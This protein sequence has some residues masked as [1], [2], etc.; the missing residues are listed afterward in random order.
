MFSIIVKGKDLSELKVNVRKLSEEMNGGMVGI[1]GQAIEE[2]AEAMRKAPPIDWDKLNQAVENRVIG[3]GLV[4][5]PFGAPPPF[6]PPETASLPIDEEASRPVNVHA[7]L[8]LTHAPTNIPIDPT[9][10]DSKGLPWDERIHASSKGKSADGSWRYRRGSEKA[11]I[12]AVENE[13]RARLGRPVETPTSP[14][15][16]MASIL[17]FQGPQTT[18]SQVAPPTTPVVQAA[19]PTH[20]PAIP[21]PAP[22]PVTLAHSLDTFKTN[23]ELTLA[24]LVKQGKITQQY[25]TELLTFFKVPQLWDLNDDQKAA[26]F[27]QFAQYGFIQKVV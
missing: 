18:L 13:L 19:Q 10:V 15:V 20:Q 8:P 23:F 17:P 11:Q 26:I 2:A 16:P 24:E 22:Q 9:N 21:P 12:L 4:E 25:I 1:T 14:A 7:G 27:E 6:T 5:S 3:P